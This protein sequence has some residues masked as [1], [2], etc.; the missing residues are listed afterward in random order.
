[1]LFDDIVHWI[2]LDLIWIRL[3]V[4]CVDALVS[5]GGGCSQFVGRFL[6]F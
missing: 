1:M 2:E 3:V 5:L 6:G 4:V